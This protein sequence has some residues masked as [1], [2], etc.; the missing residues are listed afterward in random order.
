MKIEFVK[1]PK[2]RLLSTYF[3]NPYVRDKK[4]NEVRTRSLVKHTSPLSYP[5]DWKAYLESIIKFN[6]L[7]IFTTIDFPK[8]TTKFPDLELVENFIGQWSIVL[9]RNRQNIIYLDALLPTRKKAYEEFLET[10]TEKKSSTYIFMGGNYFGDLD[11]LERSICRL[12][13]F[14]QRLKEHGV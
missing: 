2:N 13:K 7:L 10:I 3:S 4:T 1:P 8:D 11:K 12:E 6:R 5:P 9:C 14:S